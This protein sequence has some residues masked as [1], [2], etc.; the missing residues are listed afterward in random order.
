MSEPGRSEKKS[1]G[2]AVKKLISVGMALALVLSVASVMAASNGSSSSKEPAMFHALSKLPGGEHAVSIL[3]TD[4]QLASVKGASSWSN[5]I[6]IEQ[7][8]QGG[9]T[10]IAMVKQQN[11]ESVVVEK[12]IRGN[13]TPAAVRVA[14][15]SHVLLLGPL[16][17]RVG[18]VV[19]QLLAA[20]ERS[21]GS[22]PLPAQQALAVAKIVEQLLTSQGPF[23]GP[24]LLYPL[25]HGGALGRRAGP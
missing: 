4:N 9:G 18:A 22:A 14:E 2:D 23:A 21:K 24:Q 17:G 13:S 11:G 10:N 7:M 20:Q 1:G 8:T 5:G 25:R 3:L 12:Q 15:L 6:V 16:T 19:E